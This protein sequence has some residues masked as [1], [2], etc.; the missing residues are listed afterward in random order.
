MKINHY[1]GASNHLDVEYRGRFAPS[2]T[3]YM[4]LGNIWV[5]LV[6]Y[7]AARQAH[8][9]WVL[10]VEDIDR[11]RCKPEYEKALY[12]DLEWLGLHWDEGPGV[13]GPFG[14]YRQSE[15]IEIYD[16]IL[17]MWQARGRVY[18]CYC[19]RARLQKISSAPHP[20]E[21]INSYDGHCRLFPCLSNVGREPSWRLKQEDE[22]VSF[23]TRSGW[24]TNILCHYAD[25]I[26]LRRADGNFNYQFAV[27][28][29][30]G[31]MRM[32]EVVRG[33]DLYPFTGIQVGLLQKLNYLVPSYLHIPLLVDKDNIRLSKRQ[34]AIT[35]RDFKEAGY[36]PDDII[37]LLAS[38][39]GVNPEKR[40]MSLQEVEKVDLARWNLDRQR[41][42]VME[43]ADGN[44]S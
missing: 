37:G 17:A 8:G 23:R 24:Q 29:D 26:V 33:N 12:E 16:G 20:G 39:A 30:D 21:R 6:S 2:P 11:E 32:T 35:L 27:S 36:T 3:G 10:R 28:V 1:S 41:I 15:R 22:E 38:K 40:P 14:P 13:G 43:R 44:G 42:L 4:H 9:K 34:H 25:D 19:N 5:A 31:M 7:L 18:P